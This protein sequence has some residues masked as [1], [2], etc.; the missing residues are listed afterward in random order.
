MAKPPLPRPSMSPKPPMAEQSE[1]TH[2]DDSA[3][4][5]ALA[6]V[7][8]DR[9]TL[10][11]NPPTIQQKQP[12]LADLLE[13]ELVAEVLAD[14]LTNAEAKA[15]AGAM[16][17]GHHSA[18]RERARSVWRLVTFL[19][20]YPAAAPDDIPPRLLTD[21][22]FASY[23]KPRT[24]LSS[25]IFQWAKMNAFTMSRDRLNAYPLTKWSQHRRNQMD[26][27][28]QW[29]SEICARSEARRKDRLVNK[30]KPKGLSK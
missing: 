30:L 12:S 13:D 29:E 7:G 8:L 23:R 1:A 26:V 25:L 15:F 9:N 5:E 18:N 16:W 20:K 2:F 27:I 28:C 21:T 3:L 11:L 17:T 22:F 19:L 14:D 10:S 6:A 4:S 24:T